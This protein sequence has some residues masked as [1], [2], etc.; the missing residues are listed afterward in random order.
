TSSPCTACWAAAG[1]SARPRRRAE[2]FAR[3]SDKPRA[4]GA[5]ALPTLPRM[6]PTLPDTLPETLSAADGTALHLQHWP[7]ADAKGTVLIVH[8]LG[9]HIGRYGH[10]AAA[11]NAA[12]WQVAG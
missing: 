1:A 2:P 3:A 4:A 8:G 12:G 9:E 5:G 10:V 6:T 7:Q 11:L